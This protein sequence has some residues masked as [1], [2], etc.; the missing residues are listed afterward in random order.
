MASSSSN[1][2]SSSSSAASGSASASTSYASGSASTSASASASASSST[3]SSPANDLF[4]ISLPDSSPMSHD[5]SL[6]DNIDLIDTDTYAAAFRRRLALAGSARFQEVLEDAS[7]DLKARLASENGGRGSG[8]E[9]GMSERRKKRMLEQFLRD[10][11]EFAELQ[12]KEV[13][14]RARE[15][16]RIARTL[17]LSRGDGAAGPSGSTSSSR[18]AGP[19]NG[20]GASSA[21]S[22]ASA[23]R[24]LSS[25]S[26]AAESDE[27]GSSTEEE[28]DRPGSRGNKAHIPTTGTCARAIHFNFFLLTFIYMGNPL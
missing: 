24:R 28:T 11:G 1:S 13:E 27:D 2:A 14:E 4:R 15:E 7:R 21:F 10:M 6:P 3:R 5:I 19:S 17:M 8:S 26:R 9:G 20:A 12:E 18:G 22:A 25:A 23:S 16:A